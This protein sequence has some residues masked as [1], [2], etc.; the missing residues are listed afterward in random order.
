MP[1]NWKTYKLEDLIDENRGISYGIVQPGK[2]DPNGIPMLKINNLTGSKFDKNTFHKVSLDVEKTYRRSRLQGGEL[3][4]SLVGSLGEVYEV[5]ESLKGVNVARALAVIPVL[6]AYSPSWVKYWLKSPFAQNVLRTIATTSVQATINL[7]ELRKVELKM[8]PK[9]EREQIAQILSALDDKIQLNLKTNQTLEKMAMALYKHWF[10]DFGP[11]QNGNFVESEL[12]LIPEGWVVK[13][14]GDLTTMK[15]G[16]S[17]KKSTRIPGEFP[18]YGSSGV[19]GTNETSLI[20]GPALIVGRKGNVGSVYWEENSS[21][22]IDTVYYI[23]DLSRPI[24]RFL[25]FKFLHTDFKKTNSDSVVPGLNRDNAHNEQLIWP[26]DGIDNRFNEK[27]KTLYDTIG[28]NTLQN[29]TLTTLRNTLLPK[30]I[31]GQ[32]RVKEASQT[33]AAA[34]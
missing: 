24:L 29:H 14:I 27:I 20:Q 6:D 8:P 19:V 15:Y 3:L 16:K 7:K 10:V 5:P 18:V 23:N 28:N 11:F 32:I 1:E 2:F 26:S 12:G 22:P 25:F 34:L 13:T 33:I 21:F 17:L 30:L 9:V 4:L 31:S